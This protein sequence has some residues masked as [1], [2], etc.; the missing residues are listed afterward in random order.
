MSSVVQHRSHSAGVS[1]ADWLDHHPQGAGL[2]QAAHRLLAAQAALAAK[3]PP[4]LKPWVRVAR[5]D[6]QQMTVVVPG[7]AHAARLRQLTPQ[8]ARHLQDAGWPVETIVVRI[9]AAMGRNVTQKPQRL[10]QPLDAQALQAF[11]AL[12]REIGPG[13]LAQ[14]IDTLL[15]RHRPA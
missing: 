6:G 7:P 11:E 2:V 1:A 8:A 10:A 9:D 14:A 5:M 4:A 3:L 15:R 12:G 13:P